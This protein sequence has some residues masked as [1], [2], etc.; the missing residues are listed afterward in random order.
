MKNKRQKERFYLACLQCGGQEVGVSVVYLREATKW[1]QK[2]KT[3]PKH[4]EGTQKTAKESTHTAYTVG[5]YT[6]A[7]TT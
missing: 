6:R 1:E 4:A 5:K 2:H 7:N 3:Q